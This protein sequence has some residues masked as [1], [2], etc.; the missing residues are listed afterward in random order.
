[1]PSELE[2]DQFTIKK[3][4]ELYFLSKSE[5]DKEVARFRHIEEKATR[6][7]SLLVVLLS[8]VAVGLPE[9]VAIVKSRSSMWHWMFV[10][11]YPL[12][13]MCVGGS[14]LFYMRSIAFGRRRNIILNDEMFQ[15]F[16]NNRYIDVIYSLSKRNAED[17]TANRQVTETK[18]DQ[19]IIAF[20]FASACLVLVF[21]T[22]SIYCLVRLN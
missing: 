12:L 7:F 17:L 5:L 2:R 18:I 13:T 6:H 21:L 8:L 22:I 14:I 20:R 19:A 16:K 15:H 4:E 10:F 11:V 9:Y 3:F 1:M